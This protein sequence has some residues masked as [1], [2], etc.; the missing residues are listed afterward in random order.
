MILFFFF[1][2][3]FL[4]ATYAPYG[5]FQAKNRIRATAAGLHHSHRNTRSE[6]C[7][8]LISQLTAMLDP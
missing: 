1:F 3:F 6:L 5:C 7:L 8:W 4:R 2:F